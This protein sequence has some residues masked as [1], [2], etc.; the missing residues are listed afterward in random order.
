M[1]V[2]QTWKEKLER[3]EPKR[4]PPLTPQT[5]LCTET[6]HNTNNSS[7]RSHILQDIHPIRSPS[8]SSLD[9]DR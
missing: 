3:R 1:E 9:A 4:R 5:A 7:S 2:V 6:C 8:N